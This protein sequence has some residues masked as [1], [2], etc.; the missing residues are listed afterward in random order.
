MSELK[1]LAIKHNSDK[2]GSHFYTKIYEKYMS[3]KKNSPISILEI[4]VG[5]YTPGKGYS[6]IYAGGESLKIWRDYFDLATYTGALAVA[7]KTN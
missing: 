2:H 1:N 4:G 6:D 7:L 5:G 3:P